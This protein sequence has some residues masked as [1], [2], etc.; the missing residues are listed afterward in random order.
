[1]KKTLVIL[2]VICCSTVAYA[3]SV[4]VMITAPKIATASS[5]AATPPDVSALL[6]VVYGEYPQVDG[7]RD[8]DYTTT[9]LSASFQPVVTPSNTANMESESARKGFPTDGDAP[10]SDLSSPTPVPEP[11]ALLLIGIGLAGLGIALRL[12]R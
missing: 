6:T 1:M 12:R 4:S 11:N 8:V 5:V 9:A 10:M 3:T 7:K 2:L